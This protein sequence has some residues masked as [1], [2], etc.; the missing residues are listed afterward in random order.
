[1]TQW[2]A[3]LESHF[4]SFLQ[5]LTSTS[6]TPTCFFGDPITW[7]IQLF[8]APLVLRAK[9]TI[10]GLEDTRFCSKSVRQLRS[11][12]NWVFFSFFPKHSRRWWQL[13]PIC[14]CLLPSYGKLLCRPT[15]SWIVYTRAKQMRF[16]DD[17][18]AGIDSLPPPKARGGYIIR[19][20]LQHWQ[21][22]KN[23]S[24]LYSH[25]TGAVTCFRSHCFLH[26]NSLCQL[27]EICH[28]WGYYFFF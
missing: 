10:K 19:N 26:P 13:V 5:D 18:Y 16:K 15:R 9:S 7:H 20:A 17:W 22:D 12:F 11:P 23:S 1:M 24:L 2:K 21:T 25:C 8:L 3:I 4:T 14:T 6:V 27:Y 28:N